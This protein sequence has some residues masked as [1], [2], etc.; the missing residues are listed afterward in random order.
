MKS[1]NT[2]L[3]RTP[4]AAPLSPLSFKTL[5]QPACVR[6][7]PVAPGARRGILL[8]TVLF[9]VLNRWASAENATGAFWKY[10]FAL[11]LPAGYALEKEASPGPALKAFGFATAP[12]RDGTRGLVQVTLLNLGE[13]AGGP[14]VTLESFA[15]QMI[16]G[17]KRRRSNWKAT[18]TDV[19]IA[20]MRAIRIAWSGTAEASAGAAASG[21]PA[22]GVMIVGIRGDLGFSLH[23][24]DVEPWSASELPKCE[25]ALLTFRLADSR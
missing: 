19:T 16:G 24:Q 3:H 22:R 9:L 18:N 11:D 5:G 25:K 14:G 10:S 6:K 13:V 23:T 8:A 7:A 4:S 17:V 21:I 12:R 15:E 20:G 2:A 1:P